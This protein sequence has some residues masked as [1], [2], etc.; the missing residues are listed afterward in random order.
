MGFK[1][2]TTTGEMKMHQM[3]GTVAR[4]GKIRNSYKI[5]VG[6]FKEKIS[7]ET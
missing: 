4:T 1:G 2:L 3:S 6:K 5:V 7:L